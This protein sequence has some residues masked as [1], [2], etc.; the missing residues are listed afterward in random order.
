[1]EHDSFSAIIIPGGYAPDKMRVHQ[2]YLNL[3]KNTFDRGAV[4][5]AIC[6]AAWVLI[7]AKVVS[8]K[9][10]TCYHTIRDDL[11]NAGAEYLDE[12][13]VVDGNLITSRKPDDLPVFC[14]KIIAGLKK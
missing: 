1:M 13:V 6:H 11:K 10:A 2:P 9:K 3:T 7:S 4:V 12:A 8:G 14:Q 5:A